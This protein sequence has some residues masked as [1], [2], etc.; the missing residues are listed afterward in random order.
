MNDLAQQLS[1]IDLCAGLTRPELFRLLEA[2]RVETWPSNSVI[3]E[4]GSSGPRLVIL[5][6][7][8]VKVYK[9]KQLMAELGPGTVLGEMSLLRDAPRSASVVAHTELRLFA[10]DRRTFEEMAGDGDPAA[11]KLGLSMARVLARRVADLN[12]KVV[13]LLGQGQQDDQ[14]E[15]DDV[16]LRPR[17]LR[18]GRG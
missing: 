10:I 16:V 18:A 14:G 5:L 3:M 17:I 2:G 4:E 13:E 7:G 8:E 1:R 9:S 12:L 6:E 15:T 11:L